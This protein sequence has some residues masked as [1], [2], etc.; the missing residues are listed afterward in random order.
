MAASGNALTSSLP[1]ASWRGP[2]LRMS[3]CLFQ[4]RRRTFSSVSSGDHAAIVDRGTSRASWSS[5]LCGYRL[6]R[7]RLR[8]RTDLSSRLPLPHWPKVV[9]GRAVDKPSGWL[10]GFS[11][12]WIDLVKLSSEAVGSKREASRAAVHLILFF[13][14]RFRYTSAGVR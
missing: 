11:F 8:Y 7:Y 5:H 9:K 13:A 4:P 3:R 14:L 10:E 12:A 1:I 2:I 6:G